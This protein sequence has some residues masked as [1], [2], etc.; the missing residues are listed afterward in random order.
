M[1][2]WQVSL[3][4]L[5]FPATMKK[6]AGVQ[7]RAHKCDHSSLSAVPMLV[8]RGMQTTTI[9]TAVNSQSKKNI[10]HF[11]NR[12]STDS[13]QWLLTELQLVQQ[14]LKTERPTS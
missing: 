10:Q 11:S 7:S 12:Y 3:A 8:L 4:C 14:F 2:A 13:E 1:K 5:K 9:C 6:I